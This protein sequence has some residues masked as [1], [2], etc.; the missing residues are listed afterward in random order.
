MEGKLLNRDQARRRAWGLY[1]QL[2]KASERDPEQEVTGVALL[3]LDACLEVFRTGLD[4][5]VVT[6][7]AP[8]ITADFIASGD[9]IRSVDAAL[10]VQQVALALGPEHVVR[11]L[12]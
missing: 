10:L 1:R 11:G 2:Q 7:L 12:R 8:V 3:T 5:P 6:R 4:D 9:P